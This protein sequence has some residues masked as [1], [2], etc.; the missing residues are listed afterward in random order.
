MG[1]IEPQAVRL[2][3][4]SFLLHV[5]PKHFAKGFVKEMGRAVVACAG[6]SRGHIHLGFERG[7]LWH[8]VKHVHDEVVLFFGVQDLERLARFGCKHPTVADL[9]PAFWVEG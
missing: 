3:E 4:G 8:A 7:P 2:D 6:V 5:R 1:E 9:S